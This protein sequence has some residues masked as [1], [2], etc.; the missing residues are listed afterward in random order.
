MLD[1]QSAKAEFTQRKKDRKKKEETT[2]QNIM[3]CLLYEAAI[4]ITI[5]QQ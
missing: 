1:I 3:A 4:T 2:G 5:R